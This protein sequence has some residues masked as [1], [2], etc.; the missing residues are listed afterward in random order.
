M[1]IKLDSSYKGTRIL[2]K[3]TAKKKCQLLNAM[4]DILYQYGYEEIIE[5]K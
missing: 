5:Q 2:F 1:E 3:E 4:I